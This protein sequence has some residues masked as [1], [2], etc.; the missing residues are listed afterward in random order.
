MMVER[1]T[2]RLVVGKKSGCGLWGGHDGPGLYTPVFLALRSL[3]G[4]ELRADEFMQVRTVTREST[5]EDLAGGLF[6]IKT[7]IP[8][9]CP[10]V[11]SL[12]LRPMT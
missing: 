5:G 8:A 9:F 1:N 10:A 3:D 7:I 2:S 4:C 6:A 12:G 11:P